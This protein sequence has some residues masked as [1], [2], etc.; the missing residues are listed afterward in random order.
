MLDL[1]AKIISELKLEMRPTARTCK[2]KNEMFLDAVKELEAEGKI[3]AT[4]HDRTFSN[5]ETNPYYGEVKRMT[6]R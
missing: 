3:I 5:G 2:V 6:L 4:Y 1:K